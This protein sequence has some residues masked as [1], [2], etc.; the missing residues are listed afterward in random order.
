MGTYPLRANNSVRFAA[1]RIVVSSRSR[2]AAPAAWRNPAGGK[3]PAIVGADALAVVRALRGRGLAPVVSVEP[4]RAYVVWILAAEPITAARART[5]LQLACQ[6]AGPPPPEVIRETIPAQDVA[7]PDKPG[8]P[9]LLPLGLD[10]RTQER[11]WLCDDALEPLVDPLGFLRD[12]APDEA[13]AMAQAASIAPRPPATGA[14]RP[15]E[16][17]PPA[18]LVISPK[19]D[20]ASLLTSPFRELARAQEVYRGCGVF[21]H[22]VD[23]AIA[24]HGLATSERH[25]VTDVCGR[26]GDE[27]TPALDAV[28]RHLDDYKPALAPRYLGRLYPHPTSCGRIRQNQPDLTARVGCNCR[29]RVPPGAYPTP[30]LH[31]VGAAD[32]PGLGDRVRQAAARGGVARAAAAAMNE[33]RKELGAKAAALCARLSDLRRQVRMLEKAIGGVETEL[34]VIVEEAGD[35]PLETPSGTLRRV[36]EAGARRFVLEV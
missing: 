26:L 5:V 12:K 24:G 34:D 13:A 30:V 21:R 31:A 22:H 14:P 18:E 29:F 6:A 35:T 15:E 36:D 7:R 33:G 16:V 28:L 19:P 17:A 23:K 27:A 4:G 8:T 3:P 9:A 1:V 20:E 11:A 10:P 25:F 32:V 2:R